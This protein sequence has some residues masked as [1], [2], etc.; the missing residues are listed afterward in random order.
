M[1]FILRFFSPL[2]PSLYAHPIDHFDLS[3]CVINTPVNTEGRPGTLCGLAYPYNR[4]YRQNADLPLSPPHGEVFDEI[5]FADF[6]HNDLKGI[7]YFDPEPPLA[8]LFMA[9]GEWSYGWWRLTFD[10]AHGNAADL[11]FTPF[12]W[13][14]L[15]AVVGTLVVP[16]MYLLAHRLWPHRLF[17]LAAATLTCFDGMFFIQS[18][19]GMIDIYPIFFILLAYYVFHVH[20]DS[21]TPRRS[22][23]TLLLT[24]TVVGL[25]IAAKW[26]ALAALA[27]MLFILGMRVLRRYL[28][29]SLP[30][31]QG[32]AQSA[33]WRWGRE[34]A[35]TFAIPGGAPLAAYLGVA[36]IAFVALP[37]AIYI[38]SW[39]PFFQRGQFHSLGD[40]WAY[41]AAA[42]NYHAH[43]KAT[44]P[45]GSPWYSWPFLYHPVLYYYEGSGLGVDAASGHN[46]VAGMENLGNP[47]IWWSSIPCVLLMPYY[48]LRHRS[49]PAA[50]IFIGFVT[51]YLPWAP[52]TRVLFLYH[53]FGGL[54]FMVLALAFVLARVADGRLEVGI[55]K[56]GHELEAAGRRIATIT[57]QPVLYIW[58]A[59]AI[60]F[61]VYFY[62]IWAGVPIADQAYL[63]RF[64]TGRMWFAT[65]I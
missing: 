30:S 37:V 40:L 22:L 63:G 25:A 26:I 23:V 20:L 31:P 38:A 39:F 48:A 46:L 62:P 65:W 36:V 16:L 50:F 52:I 43:L 35:L 8:K 49:Y 3:N 59:V 19:I 13:R 21:A 29:I 56:A 11:G 15:G 60:A 61:F 54:I 14:W 45:Y 44:H 9:A 27:S 33:S 32:E 53:M 58:L 5:Y 7:R 4:G 42:F 55:G 24:G 6:A 12:G 18:R 57:G 64:P 34:E 28:S 17:A 1:A 41:Q 2:V 10:G 47:W 51:Q